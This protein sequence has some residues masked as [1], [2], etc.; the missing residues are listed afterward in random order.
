MVLKNQKLYVLSIPLSKSE[1]VS[2]IGETQ[3]DM[4]KRITAFGIGGQWKEEKMKSRL[5]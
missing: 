4:K 3:I 5:N 1:L 2:K